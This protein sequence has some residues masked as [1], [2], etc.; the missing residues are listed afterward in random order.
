M[1]FSGCTYKGLGPQ[2]DAHDD[3]CVHRIFH[4]PSRHRRGCTWTGPL[5]QLVKHIVKE[6]CAQVKVK[7]GLNLLM[8][9]VSIFYACILLQIVK[10]DQGP[11]SNVIGNFDTPENDVFTRKVT[12]HW[13]PILLIDQVKKVL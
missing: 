1:G 5:I 2:L 12:T 7:Q 8:V 6:R 10:T 13:K 11:F 4:C 3:I 9:G